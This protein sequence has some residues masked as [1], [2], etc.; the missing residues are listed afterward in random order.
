MTKGLLAN[1]MI[2]GIKN[3][4]EEAVLSKKAMIENLK[5]QLSKDA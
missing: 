1:T 4:L 3:K 2:K 5:R